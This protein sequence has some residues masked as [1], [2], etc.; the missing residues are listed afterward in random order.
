VAHAR[1]IYKRASS[2]FLDCQALVFDFG[3]QSMTTLTRKP[4][5]AF[6]TRLRFQSSDGRLALNCS[7]DKAEPLTDWLIAPHMSAARREALFSRR[8]SAL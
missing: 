6:S 2:R 7:N 8:K 5:V 4:K 1:T 3:Q